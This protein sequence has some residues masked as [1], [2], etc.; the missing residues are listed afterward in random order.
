MVSGGHQ[1]RIRLEPQLH[2]QSGNIILAG[3]LPRAKRI[4]HICGRDVFHAQRF[5]DTQIYAQWQAGNYG[6]TTFEMFTHYF[7]AAIPVH[8]STT[9]PIQAYFVNPGFPFNLTAFYNRNVRELGEESFSI[10]LSQLMNTY[11]MAILGNYA[12]PNGNSFVDLDA[13]A[14]ANN[15]IARST[16]ATISRTEEILICQTGWL[17][18]LLLA[19]AAMAIAGIAS[20][21][22]AFQSRAPGLSLD[23]ST[24]VALMRDSPHI[25]LPRIAPT[26]QPSLRS[27]I[28]SNVEVKLGDVAPENEVGQMAIGSTKAVSNIRRGRVYE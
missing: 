2:F 11:W 10:S 1:S 9:S 15:G 20:I 17:V 18:A 19:T 3:R 14:A 28:L 6:A 21:V 16:T 22:L 24:M 27:R 26:V 12:V 23:L 8:L 13:A 25:A 7:T 4:G 5:F